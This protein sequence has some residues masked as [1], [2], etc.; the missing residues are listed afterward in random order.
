M[1]IR[2]STLLAASCVALTVLAPLPVR[3]AGLE[4]IAAVVNDDA[5]SASDLSARMKLIMTSSGLPDKPEIKEKMRPQIVNSLIEERLMMQ[6]A[7]RAG[8]KV[9]PE[10]IQQ[11]FATIAQQNG[12][13][14]DQFQEML[15]RQNIN[16]Q[17][18][19]AQIEAQLAWSKVIQIK[20]RPQVNITEAQID[21]ELARMT[22]DIGKTQYL[23]AEI[24][25]PV[26]NPKQES[27]ARQLSERLVQQMIESHVP[28]QRVAAQ[29]SQAPGAGAGGDLGW[30][31]EGQLPPE[32]D[33]ALVKME[34]GGL[35]KPIRSAQGYHILLLREKN[36]L[37][38]D[39]LPPRED[40][41]RK[42]GIE[43]LERLQRKRLLDLK[44][45][46][47]IDRRGA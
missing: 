38:A 44:S 43:A 33:A 3:A 28:F 42:L 23:V 8:A 11:G 5:I 46:A 37:T 24:F 29:F 40:V 2:F 22:A 4:S 32:V 27:D 14:A 25:L 16:R 13:T 30:I 45:A 21:T 20:L 39:K 18:L 31:R 6:E 10:E 17:T 7:G 41:R 35:S 36:I 47:F 19:A 34:P 15:K 9:S 12:M 1:T 26:E